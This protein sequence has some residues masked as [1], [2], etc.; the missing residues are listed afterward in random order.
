MKTG[1]LEKGKFTTDK[2]NEQLIQ[3]I[4]SNLNKFCFGEYKDEINFPVA[5]TKSTV[6]TGAAEREFSVSWRMNKNEEGELES[7]KII[8]D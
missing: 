5:L 6:K 1:K 7:V 8:I 3:L 2:I 4:T